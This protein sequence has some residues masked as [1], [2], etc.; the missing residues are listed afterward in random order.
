[1]KVFAKSCYQQGVALRHLLRLAGV[2]RVGR[3]Q[4]TDEPESA[5]IILFVENAEFDDYF[6]DRLLSDPLIEKYP[7]KCFIYNEVDY[8]W[9]VLP[10]LY[11]SMP[12]R[13]FD[14]D[15]H[16]VFTYLFTANPYIARFKDRASTEPRWLY[17]FQGAAN[18][19]VRRRIYR[20][21]DSR[22]HIEDTGAFSIWQSAE[23]EVRERQR[24]YAATLYDSKY[25]LCPRGTG[26]SSYRLYE[27][28]QAGRVPVVISDQWV[29]PASS[30]WDF[31]LRVRENQVARLPE[32]MRAHE[33]EWTDRARQASRLWEDQLA[34]DVAFDRAI[35]EL[36]A[37]KAR[38]DGRL[39]PSRRDLYYYRVRINWLTLPL[40]RWL[41][42]N[43]SIRGL[44]NHVHKLRVRLIGEP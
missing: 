39:P 37:L 42:T 38:R 43:L 9:T 14:R 29:Q 15:Y 19:Q 20:L 18:H 6:Y 44:R 21:S 11:S 16:R 7:G 27:T 35:E 32:L 3:H 31:V 34:H 2:D 40:T 5:D 25:V 23:E 1:M 36:A 4:I 41:Q 17:S 33:S 26:T 22:A 8:P 30:Q 10:G 13:G 28:I 12:R 24:S